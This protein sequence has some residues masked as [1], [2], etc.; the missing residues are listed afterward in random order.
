MT[1]K[2]LCALATSDG[3]N[4]HYMLDIETVSDTLAERIRLEIG[5][6]LEGFLISIDN[7]GI[8]HTMERHGDAMLESKQ[9]QS[10]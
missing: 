5:I 6:D 10:C 2:E 4:K 1:I 8:R 3:S 7:Y 9:G